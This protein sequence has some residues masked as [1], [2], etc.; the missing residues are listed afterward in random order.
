MCIWVAYNIID[1]AKQI[2]VSLS[3][4]NVPT[5]FWQD[6]RQKFL[7]MAFCCPY[8]R[9]FLQFR[10]KDPLNFQEHFRCF[11]SFAHENTL[12]HCAVIFGGNT[13]LVFLPQAIQQ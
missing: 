2:C 11:A 5:Q 6:F 1:I 8:G 9:F 3:I 13:S 10:F 12:L 4:L 7:T